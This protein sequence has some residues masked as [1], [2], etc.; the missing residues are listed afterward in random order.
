MVLETE[1]YKVKLREIVECGRR[2][3]CYVEL[4]ALE[5]ISTN[6]LSVYVKVVLVVEINSY[7]SFVIT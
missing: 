1:G 4:L 7:T 2:K 6:I 3:L 5:G